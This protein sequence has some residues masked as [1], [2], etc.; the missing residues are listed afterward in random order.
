MNHDGATAY[1]NFAVCKCVQ[2][3]DRFFRVFAVH[4]LHLNLHFLRREVVDRFDFHLLLPGRILD[5][6]DERIRGGRKR[7]LTNDDRLA[8]SGPLDHRTNFQL[9]VSVVVLRHV[10]QT[11]LAEVGMQFELLFL[12]DGNLRQEQFAEI[13]GHDARGQ[14]HGNPLGSHHQQQRQL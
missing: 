13:V 12:Q 7:D 4:K 10:H 8:L 3:L 6:I 1:G 9:S 11:A 5:R 14:P 2:R